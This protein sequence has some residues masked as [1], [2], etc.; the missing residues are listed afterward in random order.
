[1]LLTLFSDEATRPKKRKID[2]TV[3]EE[4]PVEPLPSESLANIRRR[5][6]TKCQKSTIEFSGPT[7]RPVGALSLHGKVDLDSYIICSRRIGNFLPGIMATL[8]TD[9]AAAP[10]KNE[11]A[12]PRL[13]ERAPGSATFADMPI[14]NYGTNQIF[15]VFCYNTE[16]LHGCS[17]LGW[18]FQD[19]VIFQAVRDLADQSVSRK[20][21]TSGLHAR[22]AVTVEDGFDFA[23]NVHVGTRKFI[24]DNNE[25]IVDVLFYI[26]VH[27]TK[28]S[29]DAVC[30]SILSRLNKE[31][32]ALVFSQM[33]IAGVSMKSAP[34]AIVDT[35]SIKKTLGST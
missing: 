15:V 18:Q 26:C 17:S 1:M 33:H 11:K 14:L 31:P 20:R 3:R 2:H 9:I 23:V 24:E 25:L 30:A 29:L 22:V 13:L 35:F 12:V 34:A 6:P 10:V 16:Y 32:K 4:P 5:V 27:G 7:I 28:G 19:T 8:R 21:L